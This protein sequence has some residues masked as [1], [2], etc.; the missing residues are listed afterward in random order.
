[1]SPTSPHV[2]LERILGLAFTSADLLFEIGPDGRIATVF[3]A[4]RALLGG[5]EAEWR[6]WHWSALFDSADHVLIQAALEALCTVGQRRT[7]EVHLAPRQDRPARRG[8]LSISRVLQ[9]SQNLSCA[10][11]LES[12]AATPSFRQQGGPGLMGASALLESLNSAL[13]APD[14]RTASLE[15]D[16]LHLG[17]LDAGLGRVSEEAAQTTR[18]RIAGVLRA[19][20]PNGTCAAQVTADK[21]AVLR[22][23]G[24]D[25]D[26]LVERLARAA[27]QAGVKISAAAASIT[28]DAEE[29]DASLKALRHALERYIAEGPYSAADSFAGVLKR[30]VEQR[31]TFKRAVARRDF[32]LVYQPVVSLR[33]RRVHHVEALARFEDGRSPAAAIRLA[34]DLDMIHDFDLAVAEA[35]CAALASDPGLGGGKVAIN[36]SGRSLTTPGVIDEL[37]ATIGSAALKGG[38]LI[39][40]TE[41]SVIAD[42]DQA[43]RQVRR[44][45]E[46]GVEVCL[47]DFGVGAASF[48]YLRR[49]SL[50]VV[51]IDGRFITNVNGDPRDLALLKHM[52]KLCGALGLKTVA[53]MIETEAV[54][55]TVRDLGVDFGQGWLFGRPMAAPSPRTGDTTRSTKLKVPATGTSP[56]HKAQ[57]G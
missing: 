17:G 55:Q 19:A 18:A 16:L 5:E 41:T 14:A 42:L 24:V 57:A 21:Y 38:I 33:D 23:E 30:T 56:L 8:R 45:R 28:L 20:S 39:E 47:D 34:E 51:K 43:E 22:A 46:V 37:L 44:L 15:L 36:L 25:P 12:Q 49:L 29:P 31:A 7:L 26:V 32:E 27:E 9:S 11:I 52:V 4:S 50:D 10:L 2:Q 1:M 48:D 40:I 54:A 35:A 3:G 6:N 13:R 53:E